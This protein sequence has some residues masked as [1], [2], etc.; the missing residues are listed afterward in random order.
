[1]NKE[2]MTVTQALT[3]LKTLDA[4]ISKK[5]NDGIY[6]NY[7]TPVSAMTA[8]EVEKLI[9]GNFQSVQDLV[10]RRN[11]IKLA[12]IMSN[13]TTKVTV[14]G[15]Q[16]TVAEAIDLKGHGIQYQ[17]T[18]MNQM[19]T[20][21]AACHEQYTRA[22]EKVED[23]ALALAKEAEST[24]DADAARKSDVYTKWIGDHPVTLVDPLKLQ[25][26]ITAYEKEI[27]EFIL[28]VDVALSVI[29]ATTMIT[30]GDDEAAEA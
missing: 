21:L 9:K 12:V 25:E 29:N 30:I 27:S 11:A 4:R 23:K 2:T 5:I 13:A 28:N 10:D 15:K 1:M 26:K 18:L 8:E 19:A 24:K 22:K 17:N 3:E 16:Y 14:A 20:Q 6:I 7:V